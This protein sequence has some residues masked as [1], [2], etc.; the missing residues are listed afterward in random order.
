MV[1]KQQDLLEYKDSLAIIIAIV[2]GVGIFR[3]PAEVASYLPCAYFI[4]LAWLI[5]GIISLLGVL[6]YAELSASFP[7]TG[8][9]YIYLRESYGRGVA[10][11]FAWTELM[12]IR[13]GSIA[14]VAF[15]CAEYMRSFLS[16]NVNSLKPIAISII[17][18]L[19]YINILRLTYSKR[20]LAILT[21]SKL[22]ILIGVI[23][24]GFLS[25][26]GTI[27]HFKYMPP[28]ITRGRVQ[29]F[30]LALIPILWTYGG[31]HENT[32]VAAETKN[33]SKLLPRALTNGLLIVIFFYF[34][35][36]FLYLYLIS[37][38]EIAHSPLIGAD[39]FR[40]I[41]G[42]Y[43]KK[44]FEGCIILSSFVC[45]HA[46]I[47]T[48]S[49]ITYAMAQDNIFFNYLGRLNLRYHT[50]VPAL[51]GNAAL[52][53][54]L[55]LWSNFNKLLF[56]TGVAVWLFFAL[57]GGSLIILR[58]KFPDKKHPYKVLWYPFVP[59]LFIVICISL[60]VNTTIIYTSQSLIGLCIIAS[61]FPIYMLSRYF[62]QKLQEEAVK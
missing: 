8:G 50:P 39:V 38:Q 26:K 23:I 61:A 17:L 32:F 57:V 54:A 29:S 58:L 24:L 53:I 9:S 6:T 12:V 11:S 31:W 43:G 22:A 33:A 27:N 47:M 15:L 30:G 46:M 40:M 3:V 34:V 55:I 19:T 7:Q 41:C 52:V 5:G 35:I 49:R 13:S 56:F 20:T 21:I 16:L 4:L 18:V 37:P 28:V 48:G 62:K 2:I 60:F 51:L 1:D 45:I 59:I 14:A 36:N 42:E 10:F 25:Y 44:A